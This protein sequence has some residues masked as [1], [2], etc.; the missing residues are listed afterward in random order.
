MLHFLF[1]QWIP[2]K[3]EMHSYAIRAAQ[4][5]SDKI[6]RFLVEVLQYQLTDS[7]LLAAKA[8]H[9]SACVRYY[10]NNCRLVD[11]DTLHDTEARLDFWYSLRWTVDG[12]PVW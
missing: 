8:A 10:R 5:T 7:V 4:S 1:S 11:Q 2:S 6:L 9:S 12:R 3:D